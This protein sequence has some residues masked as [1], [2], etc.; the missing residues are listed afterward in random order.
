MP[1]VNMSSDRSDRRVSLW[2]L[3]LLAGLLPAFATVIAVSISMHFGL[4]ETCNPL[5]A[6]CVSVSRAA[7]YDLANH[8]FRALLLPAA[9]LQCLTWMLCG[10]W[11]RSLGAPQ[12][13]R[14]KLLPWLGALATIFLVLYGAFLGTEG[15][16]YRWLR[17]YGT[18]G[19]FSATYFCLLI[20]TGEIRGLA[21]TILSLRAQHL[22]RVLLAACVLLLLLGLANAT[23]AP[24]FANDLKNRIE[25]IAEWWLGIGLTLCFGLLALLWRR[26][27]YS[28]KTETRTSA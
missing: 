7:R 12:R 24:Y 28:L 17:I 22:D 20:A 3:P 14:L 9:V 21:R 26:T 5:F 1:C 6:G 19:Y 4:V 27:G 11:L 15:R 16:A 13:L 2:P 25:N 23:V 18:I 8:V 10:D